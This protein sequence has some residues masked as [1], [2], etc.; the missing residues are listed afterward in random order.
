[1]ANTSISYS[2][3]SLRNLVQII[4]GAGSEETVLECA[5]VPQILGARIIL[6]YG[7]WPPELSLIEAKKRNVVLPAPSDKLCAAV[8][9]AKKHKWDVIELDTYA[10]NGVQYNLALEYIERMKIPCEHIWFTDADECIDPDNLRSLL[11]DI[12]IA[13][14]AGV[15]QVRFRYKTEILPNWKSFSYGGQEQGNYGVLWGGLLKLGRLNGF[16]GNYH[17]PVQ[18]PYLS[19]NVPLLHLHNFRKRAAKRVFGES[20]RG[21]GSV[22]DFSNSPV[23]YHSQYTEHLRKRY[24]KFECEIQTNDSYTGRYFVT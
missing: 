12:A 6:V 10:Y 24:E 18:V 17:F 21:G 1:M 11:A 2:P 19:T 7:I 9:I 16:D 22:I 20:W 14:K 5:R 8:E 4:C 13:K 15:E 23:L 3:P